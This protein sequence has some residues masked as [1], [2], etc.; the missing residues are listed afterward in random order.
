M[1]SRRRG[2]QQRLTFESGTGLGIVRVV[3]QLPSGVISQWVNPDWRLWTTF[4]TIC[5][6]SVWYAATISSCATSCCKKW[7]N[8]LSLGCGCSVS[9]KNTR[10]LGTASCSECTA[11]KGARRCRHLLWVRPTP[12]PARPCR[13]TSAAPGRRAPAARAASR[14]ERPP[15]PAARAPPPASAA[16][17]AGRS[18]ANSWFRAPCRGTEHN[19]QTGSFPYVSFQPLHGSSR[20]AKKVLR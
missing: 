16:L 13:S 5:I 9:D 8:L 12:S 1:Q 11:Y 15:P 6:P 3:W 17:G 10:C 19:E 20:A 4:P 14:P 7:V 18:Q 2:T